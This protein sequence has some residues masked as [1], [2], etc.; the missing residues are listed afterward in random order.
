MKERETSIDLPP[1]R[2]PKSG[3]QSQL[4]WVLITCI[5][6]AGGIA[7][8][9]WLGKKNARA[10]APVVEQSTSPT[11]EKSLAEARLAVSRGNW[12]KAGQIYE[13]VLKTHPGNLEA[14]ASLPLVKKR[15][16]EANGNIVVTSE[17]EGAKVTIAGRQSMTTPAEI[18][19]L[20]VGKT[21]VR[22]EMQG[23]EPVVK[24]VAVVDK[25]TTL[26][27]KISLQKSVGNIELVSE[28]RGIDFKIIKPASSGSDDLGDVVEIGKTPAKVESLAAGEYRVLMSAEGWPDYSQLVKVEHNRSA[29][30]SAVFA[31]GG[32][33]I[34][35]DP[36][37]AE[38][39]AS[40]GQGQ[41]AKRGVTPLTLSDLPPGRH[42]VELRYRDWAP[43]KR[44]VEV[45][46]NVTQNLEFAWKRSMVT[47][48]SDPDGAAVYHNNRRIGSSVSVTPFIMEV[49]EGDYL[50]EARHN[51]L[52]KVTNAAYIEGSQSNQVHFPFAYGSVSIETDPPGA[53]VVANG[54][55]IGRTP[56]RK[57]V[58]SP[59]QYSYTLSKENYKTASL[60]G[61]VEPGSQLAFNTKLATDTIPVVNRNFING[62]GQ[63]MIWFENLG[64]W[65]ADTEMTQET[66][67]RLMKE[68][69]SDFKDPKHPVDSVSWYDATRCCDKLTVFERG[70]GNVPE[71]YHYRLPSD[72]EWSEFAGDANL[73]NAI[74]S[75]YKKYRSSQP[76]G[77]A[78]P[79]SYGLYDIRGNVAEWVLDWY[80]QQILNLA[81]KEGAV[82]R[83]EW[84]GTERKVLRGGSWLRSTQVTLEKSYRRG[85]RPSEKDGNDIGFRVVLMPQ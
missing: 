73:T 14:K 29:S 30:V 84:V 15:L 79:N 25:Q 10:K 2:P 46:G 34:V 57:P 22:I 1:P 60:S 75:A 52:M 71:G 53:A 3:S 19:K 40:L 50:F 64:G 17:P 39:W 36:V 42:H 45:T 27:P 28:P 31:R 83:Q 6:L 51:G 85:G 33:N 67:E 32:V 35:S 63:Q 7:G 77:S 8:G 65:V 58:V 62:L 26:L 49:P 16:E 78:A 12:N 37:G 23:F 38:V 43:I 9:I 59:G 80:S 47:F 48:S 41:M 11:I 56:L 24:T 20:P 61:I 69:P 44:T 66:Y 55:P 4:L 70:L 74:S 82:V 13:S 54:I 76:V 21:E 18:K 72:G 68:N 81:E 5:A